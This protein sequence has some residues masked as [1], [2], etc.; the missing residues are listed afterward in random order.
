MQLKY[1]EKKRQSPADKRFV[2]T[3]MLF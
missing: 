3:K 1:F 2:T